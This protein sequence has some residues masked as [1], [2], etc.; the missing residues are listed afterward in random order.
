[1]LSLTLVSGLYQVLALTMPLWF[2]IQVRMF[3]AALRGSFSKPSGLRFK[4]LERCCIT[5]GWIMR[6]KLQEVEGLLT[7]GTL[8][9]LRFTNS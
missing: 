6:R 8:I 7:G 5:G 4:V 3:F 1:L 2:L 9:L